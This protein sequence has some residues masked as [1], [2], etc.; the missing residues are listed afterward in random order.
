MPEPQITALTLWTTACAPARPILFPSLSL[1]AQLASV[2]KIWTSQSNCEKGANAVL[3]NWNTS[4]GFSN[5]YALSLESQLIGAFSQRPQLPG[6]LYRFLSALCVF[7]KLFYCLYTQHHKQKLLERNFLYWFLPL[8]RIAG[9]LK[10]RALSGC[11]V[12]WP[13]LTP[14][15]TLVSGAN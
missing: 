9:C 3:Q 5:C 13:R 15:L 11:G 4:F 2:S 14:Q 7:I 6:Q 1:L 8:L 12:S 10:A